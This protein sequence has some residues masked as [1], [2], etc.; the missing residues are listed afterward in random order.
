MEIK[1]RIPIEKIIR[2]SNIRDEKVDIEDL[3]ASIDIH[4]L[5][6]PIIVSESTRG[7]KIVAG[8][9]RYLACKILGHETI[10]AVVQKFKNPKLIQMTEN[11]QR[12]NLNRI[13]ESKVV[14]EMKEQL[15]CKNSDLSRHLGKN[16]TW[17][18]KR[19]SFHEVR[20]YLIE[21]EVLPSKSINTLTFDIA[22]KMYSHPKNKWLEMAAASLGKRWYPEDL[23]E[24]FNTISDPDG[25]PKPR[26]EYTKKTDGFKSKL[27]R[28]DFG[29]FHVEKDNHGCI[30]KIIFV[31]KS[32]YFKMLELLQG[33]GG[34]IL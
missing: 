16:T 10:P 11:I 13:E 1:T 18:K 8:H 15:S 21:S 14:Y 5:L 29:E 34:E 30:I 9:R 7:Y 23:V 3:K 33:V 12:K 24:T 31:N 26:K 19:V 4:G 28:E 25:I 32:A 20:T 27:S 22:L 6:Q 2:V 17:I